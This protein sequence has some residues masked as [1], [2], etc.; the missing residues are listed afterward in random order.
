MR[1]IVTLRSGVTEIPLLPDRFF[2]AVAGDGDVPL[3]GAGSGSGRACPN[4]G[5]SFLPRWMTGHS[6][7]SNKTEF[8]LR[9]Q[10]RKILALC[11]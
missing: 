4:T 8:L 10:V 3:I 6:V 5:L 2:G 11:V 9:L 7:S 1:L